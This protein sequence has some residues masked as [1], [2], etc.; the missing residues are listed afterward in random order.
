MF[1]RESALTLSLVLIGGSVFSSRIASTQSAPSALLDRKHIVAQIRPTG[2]R[3]KATVPDTLDLA[4][5]ARLA[6]HGLTA[7]L[8]EKANYAPYGHT[9]WNGNP[10]YLADLPGRPP[11]WAK[12]RRVSSSPA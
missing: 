2:K 7:F 4:E 12:S 3:Y 10:P 6:V 11:N 1:R 8:D 9:Y 5:R